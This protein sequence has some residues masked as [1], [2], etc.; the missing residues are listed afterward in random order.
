MAPF[1]TLNV[2]LAVDKDGITNN[3]CCDSIYCVVLA[4]LIC[5]TNMDVKTTVNLIHFNAI[6]ERLNLII[7]KGKF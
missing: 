5:T 6:K 4:V 2:E 7:I 1:L 3:K